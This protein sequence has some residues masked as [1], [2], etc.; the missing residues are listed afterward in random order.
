[1]PFIFQRDV[2]GAKALA[3]RATELDPA[4]FFPVMVEGWDD[5]DAGHYRDALPALKPA[6]RFPARQ[7][8][9]AAVG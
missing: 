1:M 8:Q 4:F 2:K 9:P 7:H 3:R 5:L 6:C